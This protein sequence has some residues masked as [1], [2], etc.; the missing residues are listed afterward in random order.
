MTAEILSLPQAKNRRTRSAWTN[1]ELAELYRIG[2]IL[3]RAGIDVECELGV[4]DEGDPWF[5]FC[6]RAT[7]DVL[8]HLA[9]INRGFIADISLLG[10]RLSGNSFADIVSEFM[11]SYPFAVPESPRDS[12]RVLTHPASAF[13]V[14]VLTIYLLSEMLRP[15]SP[16]FADDNLALPPDSD[17]SSD[18][19]RDAQGQSAD[20]A[21]VALASVNKPARTDGSQSTQDPS[22]AALVSTAM[23]VATVVIGQGNTEPLVLL[24]RALDRLASG[25]G[26]REIDIAEQVRQSGGGLDEG[27]RQY[28][29]DLTTVIDG[30]SQEQVSSHDVGSTSAS[31]GSTEDFTLAD[32]A[33]TH[34]LS[35]I[36]LGVVLTGNQ[37]QVGATPLAEPL[38]ELEPTPTPD[39]DLPSHYAP[40]RANETHRME[41][42][43]DRA[44]SDYGKVGD[45]SPP[46]GSSTEHSLDASEVSDAAQASLQ[47][48]TQ[49][50]FDNLGLTPRVVAPESEAEFE[51]FLSKILTPSQVLKPVVQDSAIGSQDAVIDPILVLSDDVSDD[52]DPQIGTQSSETSELQ[53][54]KSTDTV[55]GAGVGTP[56]TSPVHDEP[57]P[58]Q[59]AASDLDQFNVY[60]VIRAFLDVVQDAEVVYYQK[61]YYIYDSSPEMELG[62]QIDVEHFQLSDGEFV[63]LIGQSDTFSA[64]L[65]LLQ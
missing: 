17:A 49:T 38:Y 23:F 61:V 8:L 19:S 47:R 60:D 57:L 21:T 29:P 28:R 26:L 27:T 13:A 50:L 10:M 58:S 33:L 51:A 56:L 5:C 25:L 32:G 37:R 45:A 22:R 24:E 9:Q 35:S 59:V 7:G 43:G 48:A 36:D 4:S 30:D 55:G 16:A 1:H 6:N 40:V 44:A 39:D 42:V 3:R 20:H 52:A 62:A 63:N 46:L 41:D 34:L 11:A 31:D 18:F 12:A 2:D 54:A 15:I 65:E 14:V 53:P 64:M